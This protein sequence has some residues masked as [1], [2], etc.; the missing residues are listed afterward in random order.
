MELSK[1]TAQDYRCWL[2]SVLQL[3][4]HL[5]THGTSVRWHRVM[6]VMLRLDSNAGNG[7]VQRRGRVF[8]RSR[9]PSQPYHPVSLFGWQITAL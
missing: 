1:H 5:S 9:H 7:R 2:M 3:V 4:L 8:E 6:A